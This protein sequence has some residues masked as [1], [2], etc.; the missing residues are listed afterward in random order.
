MNIQ[1]II[2]S[3]GSGTRLWPMSRGARPKQFL[4]LTSGMSLFQET[5]L[6]AVA[7]NYNMP[8]VV[9]GKDHD[10]I[11]RKQL[12]EVGIAARAIV[13]EPMARNTAAVAAVAAEIALEIDPRALVLLM[14]SDHF[15]ADPPGFQR[16]VAA[17]ASAAAAGSLVTLGIMPTEPQT[18]FGYIERGESI[19]PSVFRVRRFHEKPSQEVA[20]CYV[21][22]GT[23][24]WNSGIFLF[25]PDTLRVEFDRLAP[26][27]YERSAAALRAARVTGPSRHLDHTAFALCPSESFDYAI[28]EKTENAAVVGP[29][30]VGWSDIGSWAAITS[31]GDDPRVYLL[32]AQGA[33]VKTDGP[34][35]GVI[36]IENVIV[37]ASEDAV[38]VVPRTRA[39]DVKKIVDALKERGREDLV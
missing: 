2:M 13:V 34:F 35:V 7:P 1:P 24:W 37:V 10:D 38:L 29:V 15:I 27:I 36:G 16:A 26:M 3:G 22:N 5:A 32:D 20:R 11:I 31:K 12:E 17:G 14:P 18:G 6:R 21:N 33:L 28:M 8:I 30:D 39:Q 23:H 25:S 4:A 9:G 19:G